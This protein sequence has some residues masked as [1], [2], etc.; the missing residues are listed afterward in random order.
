LPASRVILFIAVSLIEPLRSHYCNFN[1]LLGIEPI[2][3]SP[4]E[5][6]HIA[7]EQALDWVLPQKKSSPKA[8]F[9]MYLAPRAGLEP[10]TCGLTVRRSTD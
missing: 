2:A 4:A 9:F 6:K 1:A 10:A 5:K 8:A 7:V 3:M